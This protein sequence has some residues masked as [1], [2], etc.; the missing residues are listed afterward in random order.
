MSTKEIWKTFKGSE[1]IRQFLWSDVK[2]A[3]EWLTEVKNRQATSSPW[4]ISCFTKTIFHCHVFYFCSTC[5]Q[6][7]FA[8]QIS[9]M[10]GPCRRSLCDTWRCQHHVATKQ[11]QRSLTPH[12]ITLQSSHLISNTSVMPDERDIFSLLSCCFKCLLLYVTLLSY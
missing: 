2:T 11:H 10:S 9:S 8:D 3:A 12:L 1:N 6:P 5:Y 4:L 7:S